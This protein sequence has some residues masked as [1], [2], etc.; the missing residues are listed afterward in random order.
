MFPEIMGKWYTRKPVADSE[1]LVHELSLNREENKDDVDKDDESTPWCYC[2][3][4]SSG[5]MILCNNKGCTIKWFQ[6]ACLRLL[7]KSTNLQFY[8]SQF[9]L[10]GCQLISV[11]FLWCFLNH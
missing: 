6:F 4:P 1:G 2:N 9:F 5:D 3:E 8:M 10:C 7:Q 11:D